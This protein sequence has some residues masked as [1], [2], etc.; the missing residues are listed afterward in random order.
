MFFPLFGG[1]VF[2]NGHGSSLVRHK[3]ATT[4]TSASPAEAATFD[5]EA[6]RQRLSAERL[7]LGGLHGRA[8]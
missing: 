4:T 2:Q 7:D 3:E 1:F 5:P 8:G 6:E